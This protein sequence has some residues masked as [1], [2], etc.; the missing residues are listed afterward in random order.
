MNDQQ[1]NIVSWSHNQ[2]QQPTASTSQTKEIADTLETGEK[3]VEV[4]NIDN[5]DF[6]NTITHNPNYEKTLKPYSKREQ[7][8]VEYAIWEAVDN[9][10]KHWFKDPTVPDPASKL[11]VTKTGHDTYDE[12]SVITEN[13]FEKTEVNE[14]GWGLDKFIKRIEDINKKT[15]EE[16]DAEYEKEMESGGINTHGWGNLGFITIA[17]KIKKMYEK[18][19]DNIFKAVVTPINDHISKLTMII[20]IPMPKTVLK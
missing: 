4:E 10:V 6:L 8:V 15:P 5:L 3:I 16:L 7:K 14:T 2:E 9:V 17:R 20:R 13:F 18:A 1:K 19:V 12:V 11:S